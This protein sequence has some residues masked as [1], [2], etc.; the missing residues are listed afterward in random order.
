MRI[1]LLFITIAFLSSCSNQEAINQKGKL[2]YTVI[3]TLKDDVSQT[4]RSKVVEDLKS[5]GTIK[6]TQNLFVSSYTETADKRAKTD[7]DF[8]LEMQ[9]NNKAE[10]TAYSKNEFHLSVR[11]KLK[12]FLAGPP[13]VYDCRIE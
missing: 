1:L 6:E 5:L 8:I 2:V 4:Q 7:Y 10:L 11:K 3:L 9:F 12:P 13:V